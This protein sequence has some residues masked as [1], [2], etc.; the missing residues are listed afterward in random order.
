MEH[1]DIVIV[2]GGQSAL[3]AAY[4]ALQRDLHPVVLTASSEASGSWPNYY[5]S[6]T[7]FSPSRYSELP[8]RPFGGDPD[9]Y[10]TRDELAGYLRAYAAELGADIR[11]GQR[12][13]A[14][15]RRDGG[16]FVVRTETELELSTDLVIAATGG[17]G[18]PYRPSLRG[19][20]QFEGEVIHAAEYRR[21]A[22]YFGRRVVVVG[23]GNSAVQI[24]AELADVAHVS[25]VSRS[26][27]KF[28]PQRPLGRDLHWWLTRSGLDSAPI[29]RWLSGHTTPV[30]DD[31][32]YRAALAAQRPD[33]R[34]MFARLDKH[35]VIWADG[36][37]ERI[38][39][40][41]L[42]TGYRP[43]L[44]YLQGTGALDGA[45]RPVHRDG[46]ATTVPG[47]GY[48]G[49]DYQRSIASATVRGVGRDAARVVDRLLAAGRPES[50]VRRGRAW[51]SLRARCCPAV[52]R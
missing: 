31:G 32:R 48:V 37:R 5:D 10:P 30:L 49:L 42:A 36:R 45:G 41:I 11:T 6:L 21:P 14:V 16:G 25:I 19:L 29:G 34:P 46:V 12:V 1:A 44:G 20:E 18:S 38:D 51:A 24:A 47:L 50:N 40:V 13:V 2:G 4:A 8:G 43:D 52:A 15:G 26:P 35:G 27:L 39:A 22:P 33:A 7:L 17:F 23:G 9:R 28:F 3:A